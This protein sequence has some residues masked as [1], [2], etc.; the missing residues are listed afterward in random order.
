MEEMMRKG[1]FKHT[2]AHNVEFIG[3]E[4]APDWIRKGMEAINKGPLELKKRK[5]LIESRF[6]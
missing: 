2:K 6:F 5:T 4:N 3:F 1:A